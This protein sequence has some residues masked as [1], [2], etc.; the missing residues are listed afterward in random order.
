MSNIDRLN[1]VLDALPDR[2]AHTL[3]QCLLAWLSSSVSAEE[4]EVALLG[5]MSIAGLVE[6]S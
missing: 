5:S 6:K 4:F 3:G 2:D 1:E